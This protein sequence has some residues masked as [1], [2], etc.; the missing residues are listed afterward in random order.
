MAKINFTPF[1]NLTTERLSLRPLSINDQ[2]AIL[3][4][5]SDN[6]N[7][8]YLDRAPSKTIDDAVDFINK[9]NEN[10]TNN[11]AI[12]W[13]IIS[14]ATLKFVGTICIYNFS[15]DLKSCEI[16]YELLRP[17][18]KQG[19]MKEAAQVVINYVFQT[20]KLKKI[21]AYTHLDN[22]DSTQ[23]LLQLHFVKSFETV[24]DNPN[25]NMY[26]LSH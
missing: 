11:E 26:T 21:I 23:L 17:F 20:V 5:R 24:K 13:A 10:V 16:G 9:V 1:P 15:D 3:A 19:I 12:Y 22:W 6:D 8:K 4:L 14:N 18:Q 2:E 25:L 7:N